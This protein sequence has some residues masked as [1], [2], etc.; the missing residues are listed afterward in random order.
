M[1]SEILNREQ[2]QDATRCSTHRTCMGCLLDDI[3]ESVYDCRQMCA[4][5]ALHYMDKCEQLEERLENYV[6]NTMYEECKE[7]KIFYRSLVERQAAVLKQARAALEIATGAISSGRLVSI[8]ELN[9]T[10][11]CQIGVSTQEKLYAA[12]AAI[13]GEG[14]ENV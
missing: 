5:S 9:N 1:M 12:I 2:L 3:T 6:S 7:D 8:G 11:R 13:D 4:K 14:K 10:Y